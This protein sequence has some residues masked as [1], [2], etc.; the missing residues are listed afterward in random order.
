MK[1]SAL[2][3]VG[4]V[5]LW[6]GCSSTAGVGVDLAMPDL[7]IGDTDM[8]PAKGDMTGQAADLLPGADLRPMCLTSAECTTDDKPIC[9]SDGVCRACEGS[10]D[11]TVCAAKGAKRCVTTGANKGV[12]AA[13]DPVPA[14][15]ENADC[16]AAMS[17]TPVCNASAVCVAC[18]AHSQCGSKVCNFATG[19]CTPAGDIAYVDNADGDTSKC[20]DATTD[21]KTKPYCQISPAIASS[22]KSIIYVTGRATA[23]T[24]VKLD[25]RTGTLTIV[26]PGGSAATTARVYGSTKNSLELNLSSGASAGYSVVVD[27]LELGGTDAAKAARGVLCSDQNDTATIALTL[28]NS[29]VRY[30]TEHGVQITD[31]TV[32][33]SNSTISNF[34]K[35]GVSSS[36]GTLSL[37]ET[38]IEN[39]AAGGLDQSSGSATVANSL[40]SHNGASGSLFGGI[41]ILGGDASI[42]NATLIGNQSKT[43][44]TSGILGNTSGVV[45]VFNTVVFAGFG[46]TTNVKDCIVGNSAFEGAAA[47]NSNLNLSG[48]LGTDMFVD[49]D[50]LDYQLKT[51][52]NPCNLVDNG[53]MMFMTLTAPTKDLLGAPRPAPAAGAY[54]IGCYEKQ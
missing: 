43:S 40:V 42:V 12:C 39:N 34:T 20:D 52:V 24:N 10:G 30:G 4:L 41:R 27:G 37:S 23:Y 48:C 31:C 53:A 9:G 21:S 25:D 3:I 11:D 17:T 51:G 6:Q 1:P 22:G 36:G 13:C 16:V 47:T 38:A 44:G 54:D 46:G 18:T 8:P 14:N 45:L 49:Y 32:D 28:R 29:L 35:N 50:N 33:V 2:W 26:G 19:A 15:S 7:T 5:A